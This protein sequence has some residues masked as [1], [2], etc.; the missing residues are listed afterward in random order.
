MRLQHHGACPLPV[1]RPARFVLSLLLLLAAALMPPASAP[2]IG[3][4]GIKV[5]IIV[6]PTG[7]LTDTYRTRANEVAELAQAAGAT[8]AKA[9]SPRATWK[10]VLDAVAGADIIVYFGHGNGYPNPYS[11]T[12]YKDRTN[13]WGLNRTTT[14][15]DR[16]DWSRTLV[17]CGEKALR[18][19]LSSTDGA[20]QRKYC[21]GGPIR[22]APGFV[23]VY[24]QA[25]YAP[26]FG[27]RYSR[28]DPRTT[29]SQARQRVRNYSRPIL[30]LGGSGF[31]ATAYGDAH[32]IVERLLEHP[33]RRYEWIFKQ[34]RGY[35]ADALRTSDHPDLTGRIWVQK[36]V[37]KGFHFGQADYWYAFAGVPRRTFGS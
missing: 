21:S 36:T 22:P 28:S 4:S 23:M 1:V 16:D 37:I 2:A 14:N 33:D 35:N 3:A 10:N 30:K 20:A 32:R 18:G 31:F 24:G 13:G 19:R 25:H 15:G 5:A 27:E 11:G 12:Q 26:G 34:G 9:Y 17:Y 8:V 7:S 6:G 29:Y